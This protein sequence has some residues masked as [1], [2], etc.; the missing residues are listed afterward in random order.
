MATRYERLN[1]PAPV[2]SAVRWV[3]VRGEVVRPWNGSALNEGEAQAVVDEIRTLVNRGYRGTIGVVTPF[4]AQ[5]DRVREIIYRQGELTSHL[6]G[7]ELLVDTVHAF[8]GDERDIILFSPVVSSGVSEGALRFLRG[9]GNLFNVAITRAGS[10]LIAVGDH[11]AAVE[12]GVSYLSAFAKHCQL[13]ASEEL[14]RLELGMDLGPEY[15][16]VQRPDQVSDWERL[17]YRALHSAGLRPVP[18]FPVDQYRLDLALL[19]GD[20][21]LDIEIDGEHH[22]DWDGELCRRDQMRNQRLMELGWDVMRLWVCEVR[23]DLDHCIEKA[24]AWAQVG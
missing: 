15:P 21:K 20:R 8:Q 7:C 3:D 17:V 14:G 2:E 18:Q 13:L 6:S 5:A 1:R 16:S 22:R 23:D 12:S 4:R 9:N 19:S 10:A 24:A 11:S